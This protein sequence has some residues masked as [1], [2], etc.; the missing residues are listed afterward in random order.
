MEITAAAVDMVQTAAGTLATVSTNA[1]LDVLP[2]R[3]TG[4]D[5]EE[6]RQERDGP[7]AGRSTKDEG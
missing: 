2:K 6:P 4:E 1:V 3:G 5:E 7:G